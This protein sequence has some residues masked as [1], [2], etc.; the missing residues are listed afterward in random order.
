MGGGSSKVQDNASLKVSNN[1]SVEKIENLFKNLDENGSR[2]LDYTEFA[3]MWTV[4]G[5]KPNDNP[6][7]IRVFE[8]YD[9]N[10]DGV[11]DMS[12]FKTFIQSLELQHQKNGH[13]FAIEIKAGA[14]AL[15]NEI[16]QEKRKPEGITHV[17]QFDGKWTNDRDQKFEI[18]DG[19]IT[20]RKKGQIVKEVITFDYK[21]QKFTITGDKWSMPIN[22]DT[23]WTDGVNTVTWTRLQEESGGGLMSLEAAEVD[24]G[25]E[26]GYEKH[27]GPEHWCAHFDAANG[28]AQSP[29][30][31][32]NIDDIPEGKNLPKVTC[33]YKNCE[34]VCLNNSHTVVWSVEDAGHIIIGDKKF[35]LAQFHYHCPSEHCIDGKSYPLCLHF[36][37]VAEDGT[38][39]VLGRVFEHGTHGNK[40]LDTVCENKPLKS[41][42]T[43][44]VKS[45]KFEL[46]NVEGSY[47]KYPGSLTT[48]PCS[49]GV[50]WHVKDQ[51]DTI[52]H[53]QENWFRSCLPFDNARPLQALNDRS[54]VKT[55]I[56]K[57]CDPAE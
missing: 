1:M 15:G 30:D 20:I 43:Y 52:S 31:I 37:H 38:L 36:V 46:L 29:I 41:H 45:V 5:L 12:E 6:T 50:L 51:I 25:W 33:H 16:V 57:H 17:S 54:L 23:V 24:A 53:A 11:I 28:S 48:P 32:K 35:N 49:E 44:N 40:F 9:V 14:G 39:A 7:K 3:A 56:C 10:N 21:K 26:W 18:S 13:R 8:R 27:N 42:E 34:A 22:G 55:K 2:K 47:V 4:V 19:V